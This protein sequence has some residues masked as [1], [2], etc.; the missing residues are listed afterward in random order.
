MKKI[1]VVLAGVILLFVSTGLFAQT[2]T[3]GQVAGNIVDPTGAVVPGAKITLTSE[4]GTQRTATSD[5]SGHYAFPLLSPGKYSL[6]VNAGGFALAKFTGVTVNITETTPIEV[7]LKLK[8]ATTEAVEVTAAPPLVQAENATQGRVIQQETIRQLPLPTRN[9]QQLLT[10]TTGTTGSLQNSSELGRGDAVVSVNGQRTT[11]NSVVINGMDAAA[12]G[13]GGTPNLAVPA[14][15]SLQEFIVQTSL[16]D[17]STGRSTGGVVAAVTKSGTNQ[18]HGNGYEFLRYSGLNANNFFLKKQGIAKPQYKRNQFGG[19]VGGPIVKDKLFL[20]TSYQGT[21]ETNGTSLLNSLATVSVPGCLSS[22][23]STAHLLKL[24]AS[25]ANGG[26]GLGLLGTLYPAFYPNGYMDPVALKI[27]Q[28]VLPNG[29]YLIPSAPSPTNSATPVP[30][31]VPTISKFQEDQFNFNLDYKISQNNTVTGKFFWADNPTIQGLYSFAGVQNALQAP[32]AATQ[33]NLKNRVLSADDM[34][35][36]SP[37]MINDFRAGGNVIT[38]DSNPD[39]PFTTAQWGITNP[40]GF[41]GA[42]TISVSNNI[43]LN[44]SPLASNFSQNKTYTFADTLTWTRGKHNLKIG[45]EFK[46][47]LV[48]LRFDAYNNGQIYYIDYKY[49]TSGIPLLSILGSGD[50]YRSIRANDYNLFVQDDWHVS[51]RLTINAGLRWDVYGAFTEEKGRFVA[52]DPR[53]AQTSP[54]LG[55]AGVAI[56]GGF[57]QAG[58]GNVAGIPK[59]QD[60]LVDTPYKNFGPRVGFAFRP[61]ADSDAV[62]FRGGYGIYY[63]RINARSFNSQVFNPPYYLV[64]L[65]LITAAGIN[66]ANPYVQVPA[67]SAFPI[68]FNNPTYFPYGGPPFLLPVPTASG[69]P[70]N[71][72]PVNGIYPDRSN[73]VTPYVQQYNFGVQWEALKNTLFDVSYVGSMSHKLTRL[74]NI[75]QSATPGNPY[76]G[77]YPFGL[78]GLAS[79]PL[80]TFVQQTSAQSSY[81]SLQA[82]VTKRYSNGLQ[83]LASY[84]WSHSIDDY[85]G[86]DVNDLTGVIGNTHI[87]YFGSSDF[88]RRHRFVASWVY[89]IPKIYRGGDVMAKQVLNNWQIAG[90]GTWQTGTPFSIIGNSSAFTAVYASFK[91]GQSVT[92][93]TKSGDVISRLNAYFDTSAFTQPTGAGN[94]GNVPRNSFVGPGQKNLD[95]S[96]VKFFP[97]GEKQ[98]IEFR[99]EFFNIFNHTNFANPVNVLASP[100]FGQILRTSTGPR[101]IQYAFKYSF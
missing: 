25:V 67:P 44:S 55:G 69:M 30:T 17:A 32:G 42:P 89:D 68:A 71:V 19:T 79:A 29:Q 33:V 101:V 97:I 87:N 31:T 14:S 13:T 27:F 5:A 37:T 21:R 95:M 18:W 93:A 98:K 22:D 78:S 7:S 86:G 94:W 8:S 11:S 15:D 34:W 49:M 64:G 65:N 4:A 45:G 3:T 76:S 83:L 23:R 43:D 40:L 84:T 99:S 57:V 28:A 1:F 39:E 70:L 36:I 75:N 10:L 56:T 58:N 61:K 59:V 41:T 24:T 38:V 85:S 12:I 82:S 26:C 53:L 91:S 60:G 50:P 92:T 35:V 62:V 47:Q 66:P 77:P 90:V 52:F 54:I 51:K 20:F 63:D 73:F 81:N 72:V 100:T 88:D 16:Y 96:L 48:N 74:R 2:S 80:G 6:E 46:K 9:F